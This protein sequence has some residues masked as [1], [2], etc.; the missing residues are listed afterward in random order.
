MYEAVTEQRSRWLV[1]EP[2]EVHP[3]TSS[4]RRP[5]LVVLEPWLDPAI[6]ALEVRIEAD[7]A[8]SALTLIGYTT[9]E[10]LDVGARRRVRHRLGS[11]FGAALREWVDE[12]HW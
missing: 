3:V 12:P 8:G 5:E 1:L 9:C 10:A 6:A 4:A 11:C 7:G 2:G